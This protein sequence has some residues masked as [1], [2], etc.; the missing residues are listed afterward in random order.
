MTEAA[1]IQPVMPRGSGT[2]QELPLGKNFLTDF[3]G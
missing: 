2:V 3:C 1:T